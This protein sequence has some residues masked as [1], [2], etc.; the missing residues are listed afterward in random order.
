M[1]AKQVAQISSEDPNIC[2]VVVMLVHMQLKRMDPIKNPASD[3]FIN[4]ELF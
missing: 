2:L 1:V 3:F 4:G